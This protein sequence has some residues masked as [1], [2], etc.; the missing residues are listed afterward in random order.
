[1]PEGLKYPNKSHRKLVTIPDESVDLAEFFGIMIGDGGINNPWQATIAVNAIKDLQYSKYIVEL[2]Q[3]LFDLSPTVKI[4]S[5]NTLV[6]SLNSTSIVDFLVKNG[7]VRGNKLKYGLKI[8]SWII[9]QSEYQRACVRGLMD[10][11]GCLYIHIHKSKWGKVYKNIGLNFRS[12]SPQ[13]IYQVANIFKIFGIEP[14]ISKRVKDIYLY[15]ES[16][17]VKYLN[18]FGSSNERIKSVYK[19]WR[20]RIVV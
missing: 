6:I 10:T 20:G 17:I 18:I 1:M 4:R 12:Y 8:P 15:Q 7:L 11:D 5:K 16:A 3:K 13:L 9:S 19:N 14:H 2:I